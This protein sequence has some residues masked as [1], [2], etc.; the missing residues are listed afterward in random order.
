M[1][2]QMRKIIV[3][4]L[5]ELLLVNQVLA[6]ENRTI[7]K[8]RDRFNKWQAII[9]KKLKD[10]EKLFHYA[11]GENY[12]CDKWARNKID[13]DTLTLQELISIIKEKELGTL[14]YNEVYSYSGD[15]YISIEY[16]YD[17]NNKLYFIFWKMNTFQPEEPLTVEKRLYFDKNGIKIRE[18]KSVYKMNTKDK[19][20]ISFMDRDVDYKLDLKDLDFYHIGQDTK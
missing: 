14:I 12:Q 18:L 13:N 10:S 16:Y 8:T 1:K 11:W 7:S 9:G 5:F 20:A 2:I 4:Y 15:W 3:I 17:L 19:T 6:Q